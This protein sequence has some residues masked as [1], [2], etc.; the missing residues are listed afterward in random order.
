MVYIVLLTV[1]DTKWT[2]KAKRRRIEEFAREWRRRTKELR[3]NI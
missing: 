3:K 1:G 2:E